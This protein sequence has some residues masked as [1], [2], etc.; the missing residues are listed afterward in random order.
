VS[1]AD[2]LRVVVCAPA[3]WPAF[4]F[5]GPI[6]VSKD[7][8]EGL[9]ARGH[10]VDV[11]TTTLPAR[12][13]RTRVEQVDG[14]TVHYL[15]TPVR[16]RWLGLAPTAGR[17]LGGLLKPDVVHVYGL[18]DPL[19]IAVTSWCRRN[20]VPYVLEPIGMF[21]ARARK[22]R[23][24]RAV[25]PVLVA[26]VARHAA[27]VV[28]TSELER[29][30]LV[31]LGLA[32]E[33]IRV[34]PNPFPP[35]HPGRTGVLRRHLG[36]DDEPLVLYV[37]RIAAGKGLALLVEAVRALP[38]VHLVLIGPR[39]HARVA[40]RLD[41]AAAAE[42]RVH[43]TGPWTGRPLDVYGDAD[44]VVL[45]AEEERENFGLVVAEAAAAGVPTVVS[46]KAGIAP[47]VAGRA[48]VVVAPAVEPIRDALARLLADP[49]ERERLGR[50]GI[51]VAT[52]VGRDAV[53]ALQESI[54]REAIAGGTAGSSREPPSSSYSRPAAESRARRVGRGD[55][56]HSTNRESNP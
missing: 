31:A 25:D 35:P 37:G 23:L 7:L 28:A 51:E 22:V 47:L 39:D 16:Y 45:P 48:A 2:N 9:A 15:A 5:G 53:V 13:S 14:V 12:S 6:W 49:A 27:L 41:A 24:K 55:G 4:E 10:A 36:L 44:V 56:H 42:P 3:Y 40:A 46:E 32:S 21:R 11:L 18:R 20:R 54:Y 33:R 17:V 19:G 1:G 30:D 52:E 8:A 38:G 50:G 43:L 29:D 34:R 26:P